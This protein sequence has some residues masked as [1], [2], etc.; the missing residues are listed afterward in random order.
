[1]HTCEVC[2]EPWE[3]EDSHECP[4]GLDGRYCNES[5]EAYLECPRYHHYRDQFWSSCKCS[6]HSIEDGW[7][8]QASDASGRGHREAAYYCLQR[9]QQAKTFWNARKPVQLLGTLP[10]GDPLNHGPY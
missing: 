1:M 4:S 3:D 7:M 10:G 9:A 2:H 6:G 5:G 8:E